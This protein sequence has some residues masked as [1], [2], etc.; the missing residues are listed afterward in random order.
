MTHKLHGTHA[1]QYNNTVSRHKHTMLHWSR[2]FVLFSPWVPSIYSQS[3]VIN[4]LR[5]YWSKENGDFLAN[6]TRSNEECYLLGKGHL[7]LSPMPTTEDKTEPFGCILWLRHWF[8]FCCWWIPWVWPPFPCLSSFFSASLH[9]VRGHKQNFK[10]QVQTLE[11]S[12]SL[13]KTFTHSICEAKTYYPFLST[14]RIIQYLRWL[15]R[16]KTW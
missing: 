14:W 9:P 4:V 8:A 13:I 11:V 6:Y 15:W 16:W 5:T 10:G 7:V 3:S 2:L 12:L 1:D